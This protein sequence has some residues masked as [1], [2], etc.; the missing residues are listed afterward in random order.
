MKNYHVRRRIILDLCGGTGSW[1]KPYHEAGYDVRIIDP[2][3]GTG[4][5]RLFQNLRR[6]VYGILA[7][8]VC[9]KFCISGNRSRSEE[10]KNGVYEAGILEALSLVD[11]CCRIILFH[12]PKFWVLENP[13]GTLVNY[14]GPPRLIWNPYDYGDPYPKRTCLWGKFFIPEK[15]SVRPEGIRKGQPSKWYSSV[16]GSSDATKQFRSITPTGFAKAF[17]QANQ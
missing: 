17:F 5:A 6:P 2:K 8:P 12:S 4:D 3:Q 9:T 11:A 13:V 16:G 10:K 14:L 1:S 7:A 15:Q